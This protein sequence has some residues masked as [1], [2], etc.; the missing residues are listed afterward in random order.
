LPHCHIAKLPHRELPIATQG[1]AHCPAGNCHIELRRSRI[2][3]LLFLSK[4][5][6]L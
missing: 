2:E 6:G 3:L 1:I 5:I 4:D